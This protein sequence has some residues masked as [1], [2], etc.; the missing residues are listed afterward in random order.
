M[1]EIRTIARPYARAMFMAGQDN[2]D[3]LLRLLAILSQA[4][5]VFE[6]DQAIKNPSILREDII[7]V[8]IGICEDADIASL[9]LFGKGELVRWLRLLSRAKR[10]ACL[11][12]I[13]ELFADEHAKQRCAVDVVI[14]SALPL[15]ELQKSAV[16]AKLSKKWGKTIQATYQSDPT[17][18]GGIKI[19]AGDWV[20]DHSIADKLLRLSEDIQS[21]Q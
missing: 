13:A 1:A 8:L 6:M 3:S 4:V 2:A 15:N 18:M 21:W 7:N 12:Q 19:Q 14:T 20:Q 17:L 5:V 16:I 11:P 9:N 10:L